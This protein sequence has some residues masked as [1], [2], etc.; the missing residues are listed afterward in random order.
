VRLGDGSCAERVA[1]ETDLETA[2]G[3][4]DRT[5]IHRGDG[6]RIASSCGVSVLSLTGF[7]TLVMSLWLSTGGLNVLIWS[8]LPECKHG[9][10]EPGE[11]TA[12]EYGAKSLISIKP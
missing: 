6:G 5:R 9:F 7:N 3:R 10:S 4:V 11:S 2:D 1:T 8:K 12:R